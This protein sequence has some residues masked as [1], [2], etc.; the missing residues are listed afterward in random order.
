M[1]NIVAQFFRSGEIASRRYL[2]HKTPKQL[3]NFRKSQTWNPWV[4]L[5]KQALISDLGK[6]KYNWIEC[7][8]REYIFTSLLQEEVRW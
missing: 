5:V 7:L 8:L 6:K 3:A 1:K 2:A 4:F